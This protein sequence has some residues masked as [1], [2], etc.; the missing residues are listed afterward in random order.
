MKLMWGP[1]NRGLGSDPEKTE[2]EPLQ[3]VNRIEPESERGQL[4]MLRR[5]L[6]DAET[7]R[8]TFSSLFPVPIL[9]DIFA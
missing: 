6:R 4:Y 2:D 9:V 1:L 5:R 8:T 7:T 3:Q